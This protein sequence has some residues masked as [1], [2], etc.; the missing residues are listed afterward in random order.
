MVPI[1]LPSLIL[2]R[3]QLISAMHWGE[4]RVDT[5]SCIPEATPQPQQECHI[6]LVTP[7]WKQVEN[8]NSAA[9]PAVTD[10]TGPVTSHGGKVGGSAYHCHA[11]GGREGQTP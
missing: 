2:H 7:W 9:P 6:V 10:A 5:R 1:P 8:K 11:V 4:E 3:Y